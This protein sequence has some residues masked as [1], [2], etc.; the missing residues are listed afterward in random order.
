MH[1]Q[2]EKLRECIA[3]YERQLSEGVS[4]DIAEMYRAEIAAAV[5]ML[6]DGRIRSVAP[7]SDWP[8]GLICAKFIS[9]EHQGGKSR[10]RTAPG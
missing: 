9:V 3:H 7:L 6:D 10:H 2:A 1:D 8:A 5:A 4:D